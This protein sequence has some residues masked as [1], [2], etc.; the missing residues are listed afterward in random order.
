[1][2]WSFWPLDCATGRPT[3][4]TLNPARQLIDEAE[5]QHPSRHSVPE[6]TCMAPVGSIKGVL[7]PV[8][9][10]WSRF[11]SPTGQRWPALVHYLRR[12]STERR[13]ACEFA[14]ACTSPGVGSSGRSGGSQGQGRKRRI[15]VYRSDS[16]M[17][18]QIAVTGSRVPPRFPPNALHDLNR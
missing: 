7:L 9:R 14:G 13:A 17:H 18:D 8:E 2:R 5:G 10:P 1:M 16:I 15:Y 11:P 12:G 6:A 4:G 3:C